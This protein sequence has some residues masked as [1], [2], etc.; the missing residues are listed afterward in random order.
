MNY[1]FASHLLRLA[2]HQSPDCR[3]IL[4]LFRKIKR[5]SHNY[6]P[7]PARHP[8]RDVR[9][10]TNHNL[11]SIEWN[12]IISSCRISSK[13][14]ERAKISQITI[15]KMWHWLLNDEL[16]QWIYSSPRQN[17]TA[18]CSRH[19]RVLIFVVLWY[20]RVVFCLGCCPLTERT[21]STRNQRS[22][23]IKFRSLIDFIPHWEMGSL[24]VTFKWSLRVSQ[25]SHCIPLPPK[26]WI[27]LTN[28]RS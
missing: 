11:F 6:S 8:E 18:T 13:P 22:E 20:L 28:P 25:C 17:S 2:C 9:G 7:E 12:G 15:F 19:H 10:T 1:T 21:H 23:M 4:I 3:C 24:F 26:T 27:Q 16:W 14:N 5:F